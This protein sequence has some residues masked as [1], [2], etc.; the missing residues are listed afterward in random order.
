MASTEQTQE[1]INY[2]EPHM[3]LVDVY[4][5]AYNSSSSDT[6]SENILMDIDHN[7]QLSEDM[8]GK[9]DSFNIESNSEMNSAF[10]INRIVRLQD[11]LGGLQHQYS[12]N[13][14]N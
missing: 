2:L 11:N 3:S 13:F 5:S 6:E 4:D 1:E 7:N 14:E 8:K 9:T 10:S 12:T